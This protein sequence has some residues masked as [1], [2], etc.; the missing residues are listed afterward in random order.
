MATAILHN[1]GPHSCPEKSPILH[2]TPNQT[3]L[4]TMLEKVVVGGAHSCMGYVTHTGMQPW[5]LVSQFGVTLYW[6]RC[7]KVIITRLQN[8]CKGERE[9]EST[10]MRK[11]K[12]VLC[13]NLSSTFQNPHPHLSLQKKSFHFFCLILRRFRNWCSQNILVYGFP[14]GQG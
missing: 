12:L 8:Y 2:R 7:T 4:G 6:R 3:F 1:F 5:K 11:E 14:A 10:E 9:K 13:Q